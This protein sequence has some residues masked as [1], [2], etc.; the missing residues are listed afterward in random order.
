MAN[1]RISHKSF[2]PR[3]M[4]WRWNCMSHVLPFNSHWRELNIMKLI[5]HFEGL[6][7]ITFCWTRGNWKKNHILRQIKELFDYELNDF[8]SAEFSFICGRNQI[9]WVV[10]EWLP[11]RINELIGMN[12]KAI[13]IYLK[14]GFLFL[15]SKFESKKYAIHNM[16]RGLLPIP[17]YRDRPISSEQSTGV[18]PNPEALKSAQPFLIRSR[19]N[20]PRNVFR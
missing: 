8:H 3:P 10:F 20:R 2:H 7:W 19:Y 15:F 17:A 5:I 6:Q 4:N 12:V 1:H 11:I 13:I 16:R 9:N 18:R 14:S